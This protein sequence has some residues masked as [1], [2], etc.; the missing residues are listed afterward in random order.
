[1]PT[2]IATAASAKDANT[3]TERLIRKILFLYFE[4][5]GQFDIDGPFESTVSQKCAPDTADACFGVFFQ[6]LGMFERGGRMRLRLLVLGS[7]FAG[8]L[9]SQTAAQREVRKNNMDL[10]GYND[11]QARSAY[12]PVIQQ[13]GA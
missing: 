1:M 5:C 3:T 6:I 2:T 12:Q 4:R 11:L 9:G 13:Q 10:V 8:F 7:V